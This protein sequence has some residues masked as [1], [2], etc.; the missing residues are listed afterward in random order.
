[1]ITEENLE[2]ILEKVIEKEEITTKKLNEFGFTSKDIKELVDLDFLERVKRGYYILKGSNRLLFYG[3]KLLSEQQYDKANKCFEI[4]HE[5]DPNN[6]GAVFQLFLRSI[7]KKEYDKVFTYYDK[8]LETDNPYY[9]QDMNYY[10]FLL[11]KITDIKEKYKEV[12]KYLRFEDIRVLNEDKR[13]EDTHLQNKIRSMVLQEKYIYAIRTIN[14]KIDKLQKKSVQDVIERTLLFQA[15]NEVNR[16]REK[17]NELLKEKNYKEFIEKMEEKNEKKGLN[18]YEEYLLILAKKYREIERTKKIPKRK[19]MEVYNL[20]HAI[21]T[22]NFTV[23]MDINQKNLEKKNISPATNEI[24]DI[25]NDIIALIHS[26]E[27]DN[28]SIKEDNKLTRD[29]STNVEE[30]IEVPK[31]KSTMTDIITSLLKKDMDNG[32]NHINNYLTSMKKQDYFPIISDLLKVSIYEKDSSYRKALI[33]LTLISNNNYTYDVTDYLK[34]FYQ[35]LANN[36]ISIAEVYLDILEKGNEISDKKI[37]TKELKQVLDNLKGIEHESLKKI[38]V[39]QEEKKERIPEKKLIVEKDKKEKDKQF[40]LKKQ[41]ELKE[42]KGILLLKYMS[43]ENINDLMEEVKNFPKLRALIVD[44]NGKKRIALRYKETERKPYT[45]REKLENAGSNYR[46]KKFTNSLENYLQA[47][48][49]IEE[50]KARLMY[51]IARCYLM[52]GNIDKAI[53]YLTVA[54]SLARKEQDIISE[55]NY[56]SFLLRLKGDIKEEDAK[57]NFS[58]DSKDYQEEKEYDLTK[59][60][61]INTFILENNLDILTAGE[62]LNLSEEEINQLLLIYARE[63]YRINEYE[64]GDLLLRTLEKRKGKTKEFT[65]EMEEVKKN[66]KFYQNRA[67]ENPINISPSIKLKR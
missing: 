58:R 11:D 56:Y 21:E 50:P 57:P 19:Y 53:E 22:N 51:D 54:V 41:E 28:N 67:L 2:K 5:M 43:D 29:E 65:K 13:Y 14:D 33:P 18:R 1:M 64:K 26:Y 35:A 3:K 39:E 48:E 40:L 9:K 7:Q 38:R 30:K 44:E 31:Q 60:N 17:M 12:L 47:L 25:L 23:A 66:K 24:G 8:L 37:D 45:V 4:C 6:L 42:N 34:E 49:I 59:F 10:L 20:E 63:F 27:E 15:N 32:I 55:Q 16:K 52:K 36:N 61:Q 62:K 46:E